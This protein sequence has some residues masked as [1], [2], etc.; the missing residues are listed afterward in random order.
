MND[1][2]QE[3][4]Q[5]VRENDV[6]FIRLAFC[7]SFGNQKNIAI[8]PGQLPRAFDTGISFDAS[9]IPGFLDVE[10]S[11]LF[12]KPDAGTLAIL[13][14]RPSQGR[15]V[16]FFCDLYRPDGT[17][18]E[19]DSR[20]LLKKAVARAAAMG[21]SVKVGAEC[22]FY[23]FELGEDGKPT[24]T[25][26]DRAGYFDVSPIDRGENV[27]REICL[28][29]EEMGILPETSHHE[30]GPGQNEID[31]QYSDALTAADE[32][33]TFKSVVKAIA[34]RNGLYASFLP[35][36]FAD[37][38]GS[39]VHVNLSLFQNGGNTFLSF[40]KEEGSVAE[41]FLAGIL[42]RVREMTLFLNPLA[43][44]YHR[45]GAF[46]APRFITWS[47]Q[48]RSQLVRIPAAT[49]EL[50]RMELRS[51]DAAM[52]PYLAFSLLINAGLDGVE[53]AAKLREATDLDLYKAPKETTALLEKLPGTLG[54]AIGL[55]QG[56]AFIGRNIPPQTLEKYLAHKQR[57]RERAEATGEDAEEDPHFETV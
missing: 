45:F 15:V 20:Q 9:A 34:Q 18:Y 7:D 55:A 57:E 6:K 35:K 56:S 8:M 48:N 28:T 38:P 36:P 16:R 30:Q 53:K 39:G 1:T 46:E 40:G 47:H 13:P 43:N 5:F 27:R 42:A 23:L 44:S 37:K 24:R 49:G 51:P 14:W 10:A 41:S 22:E 29:L 12:L 21:Y 33:I 50:S 4:L 3:V 32:F 52:N 19:G 2:V 31:F 11:D 54:E 26:Q 25:P 17:L